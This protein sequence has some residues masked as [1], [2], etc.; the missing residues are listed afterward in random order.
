MGLGL[1]HC[2][3]LFIHYSEISCRKLV[4]SASISAHCHFDTGTGQGR[5]ARLAMVLLDPTIGKACSF[6]DE[7]TACLA[8]R[9]SKYCTRDQDEPPLS[10]GANPQNVVPRRMTRGPWH[11]K[12]GLASA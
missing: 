10:V 11:G 12:R 3:G 1:R 4:E 2:P 7:D 9:S 8:V 6:G 5:R